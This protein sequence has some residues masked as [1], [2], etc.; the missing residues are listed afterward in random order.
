MRKTT[1]KP[2][3]EGHLWFEN[4]TWSLPNM[5]ER[6]LLN[7][8]IQSCEQYGKVDLWKVKL[9]LQKAVEDYRVVRHRGPHIF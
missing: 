6:W 2:V 7:H 3:K 9:S 5:N 8:T 1:E 4:Q